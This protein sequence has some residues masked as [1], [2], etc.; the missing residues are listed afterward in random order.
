MSKRHKFPSSQQPQIPN[1]L[2]QQEGQ[3]KLAAEIVGIMHQSFSGP[4]PPPTILKEYNQII[5]N[6]A[7]RIMAMAEAQSEHR[8]KLESKALNTDSRNSLW[9]LIFAFILGMTVVISGVI[10]VFKGY[11]TTGSFIST[12][13]LATLLGS[14][15]YGTRE[16]RKEREFKSKNR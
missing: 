10:V 8:R 6:G 4:I 7:E 15:I 16:R 9:G 14:F 5:P 13:G 1:A 3:E 2:Q 11:K 12:T